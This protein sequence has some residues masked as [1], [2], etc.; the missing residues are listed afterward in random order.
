MANY[1]GRWN[2]G[3]GDKMATMKRVF[4]ILVLFLV[5]SLAKADSYVSVVMNPSVLAGAGPDEVGGASFIWDT[6]TNVLSDFNVTVT[7]PFAAFSN[8]ASWAMAGSSIT[9]VT[10]F[11]VKDSETF[12]LDYHSDY[13]HYIF[14]PS[15]PGGSISS[16]PGTYETFLALEGKWTG[17]GFRSFGTATVSDLGDGDHDGDDPVSTP[18]PGSLLL[19][20]LGITALGLA[21]CVKN[22]L[23]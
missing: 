11:D 22:G 15:F 10:F 5:P 2:F 12:S 3:K 1:C 21:V 14:L 13:Y 9:F 19:L 6:T 20:G 7:G 4:I 18:E 17:N 16:T 23:A 8:N